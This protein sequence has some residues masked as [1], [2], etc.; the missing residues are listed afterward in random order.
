MPTL[1][2]LQ[3]DFERA[4]LRGEDGPLADVVCGDGLDAAERIDV[5]RNNVLSS[6]TD[7]LAEA[8]PA[9]RRLVDSRFFAYAAHGFIT[10]EPP[11][12]PRLAEYGE[13]FPA[14]IG[15]FEPSRRLHYLPDVARLEWLVHAAA[16]AEDAAG[17]A[18]D[19]LTAFAPGD[20]PRLVLRLQP[21]YGYLDSAWPVDE[22]WEANR[23]AD[24]HAGDE[25]IDLDTGSVRLEIRRTAQGIVLRTLG[26]GAFAFRTALREQATLETAAERAVT[27]EENFDLAGAL[28]DLFREGAVVGVALS[29]ALDRETVR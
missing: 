11:S 8:F 17:V 22:I 1:L 3:R 14:F 6:L 13:R 16:H 18:P 12:R 15:Q 28:A 21:S 10:S 26:A 25:T 23:D 20:A 2:E 9:V 5:Y 7:V 27:A 29:D 24:A 4:L 19:A